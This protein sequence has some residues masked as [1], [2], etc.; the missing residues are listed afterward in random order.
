M[1]ALPTLEESERAILDVFKEH[2]TRPDGHIK[3]IALSSLMSGDG[4]FKA[5]DLNPALE[6][7]HGKKWID[8]SGLQRQATIKLLELGFEQ[9]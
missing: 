4:G 6:S 2:G 9:I 8:I 5:D 3:S 7:M 1:A